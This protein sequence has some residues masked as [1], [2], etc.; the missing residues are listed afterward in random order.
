MGK[1]GLKILCGGDAFPQ[2]LAE[3]LIQNCGYVYNLYG[4]T[5]AAIQCTSTKLTPGQPIT[6]GK[7][8][9]N[10]RIY[11]LDAKRNP[12]PIGVIGE[13][14]ISG[15]GLARGYHNQPKLTAE[16][17]V[18][19]PFTGISGD[20]MYASGDL[21]RFH[22]NGEIEIIG[23][24]DDQVKVRGY[25]IEPGEIETALKQIHGIDQAIV[26]VNEGTQGDKRLIAFVC[27][28]RKEDHESVSEKSL[29]ARTLR[30]SLREKI[31]AY[32]LPNAFVFL[33]A[34]PLTAN[35]KIDKTALLKHE[36][37]P[38][39]VQYEAPE[40]SIEEQLISIWQELLG[41][42]RIGVED[43]FFES[44]GHS[45]LAVR[46]FSKIE[47]YFDIKLP[48]AVLFQNPTI[49]G[50]ALKIQSGSYKSAWSSLVSIKP[51]GKKPPFFIVHGVGGGALYYKV[52]SKYLD[53]DQPLY[54]FQSR[55][56]DLESSPLETI[57]EMASHYLQEMQ[58]LYPSGPYLIG[59]HSFG[60]M[61]A[62]EMA[63]QLYQQGRKAALVAI[64]DTYANISKSPDINW[65][66]RISLKMKK[67]AAKIKYH[68]HEIMKVS[69]KEKFTYLKSGLLRREERLHLQKL[70]DR[71]M[72]LK[73]DNQQ[74]PEYIQNVEQAN[75]IAANNYLPVKYPGTITLFRAKEKVMVEEPDEITNGWRYFAKDVQVC[76]V[77]GTH[78]S[79]MV[80]PNISA[81]AAR[82]Q[83]ILDQKVKDR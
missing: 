64:F 56:F 24:T 51:E 62:Y 34:I 76:E 27:L 63:I 4:P 33:D 14:Y 44:G 20:R 41:Y 26:L 59:G 29:D 12:V 13:L 11:I 15:E 77:P 70:G 78:T 46:L 54:G 71:I 49:K 75:D 81:L 30:N 37:I 79:L 57:E 55:G 39:Q 3:W 25:R 31:P 35:G 67:L 40:N 74:I 23:R 68:T 80:E 42:E 9:A 10:T 1:S 22:K 36:S 61:V 48:L 21:A 45:L 73:S 53:K 16:K 60:G 28:S 47:E 5:E 19:N 17:F 72:K 82:L 50:L 83:E 6:V 8:I 7:P 69:T 52:L 2:D 38:D 43:D 18:H 58:E 65:I 32:M 66:T